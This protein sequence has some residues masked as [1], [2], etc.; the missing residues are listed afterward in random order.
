M[1][2]EF[3]AA[4]LG[5][6][7]RPSNC[8]VGGMFAT[9]SRRTR[10][11]PSPNCSSALRM[12][13]SLAVNTFAAGGR[14]LVHA[15][16]AC[17]S[18]PGAVTRLLRLEWRLEPRPAPS[19][20]DGTH[21]GPHHGTTPRSRPGGTTLRGSP[22]RQQPTPTPPSGSGLT[23]LQ[24]GT[25]SSARKGAVWLPRAGR[26]QRDTPLPLLPPPAPS[27]LTLPDW[28]HQL[29]GAGRDRTSAPFAG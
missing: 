8:G 25:Y 7:V 11:T 23:R 5:C 19:W 2:A 3:G 15:P 4:Q 6:Y 27:T 22:T 28:A 9:V 20:V 12:S 1:G 26:G 18:S 10:M 13:A 14:L 17:D 21:P 16:V 24:A 29:P